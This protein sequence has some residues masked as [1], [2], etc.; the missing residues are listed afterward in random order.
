MPWRYTIDAERKLVTSTGW[1]RVTFGE[2]QAHQDQLASDPHFNPEFRQ[3]VDA[4]A[5][6]D[7]NISIGEARILAG[8]RMFSPKSRR[9][10]LGNGLS[11]VAAK[12]LMQAYGC[13][14]KG[15]EEIRVFHERNAAL[16]WLGMVSIPQS[17]RETL[18]QTQSQ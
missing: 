5:V 2:L 4:T 6:A 16:S 11:I 13:L 18:E 17:T 1:G 12:L 8:R 10:F 3:L 7:L 15:R 9:A 14:A